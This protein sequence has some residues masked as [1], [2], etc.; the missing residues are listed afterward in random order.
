[1]KLLGS[2]ESK[3]SKVKNSENVPHL[4]IV[5]LDLIHFNLF[6]VVV[7]IFISFFKNCVTIF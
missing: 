7:V 4:A 3:I 5:E 1:M 6:F 2:T